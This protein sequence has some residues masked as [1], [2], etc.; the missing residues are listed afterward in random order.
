MTGVQ[1]DGP[2]K[3]AILDFLQKNRLLLHKMTWDEFILHL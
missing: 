1:F 3:S 2:Y